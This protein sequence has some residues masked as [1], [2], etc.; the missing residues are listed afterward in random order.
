MDFRKH[1]E[2]LVETLIDN[3]DI[4]RCVSCKDFVR[5]YSATPYY[6]PKICETCIKIINQKWE[7]ARK[8]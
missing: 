4:D 5:W 1:L 2:K 8:S 3:N 6:H 7:F